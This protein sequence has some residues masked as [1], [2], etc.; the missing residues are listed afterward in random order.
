MKWEDRQNNCG[1]EYELRDKE[2]ETRGREYR[3]E[4]RL[5]ADEHSSIMRW[6]SVHDGCCWHEGRE[7]TRIW[8]AS[9][10]DFFF[11]FWG[12]SFWMSCFYLTAGRRDRTMNV[13]QNTNLE[14]ENSLKLSPKII[15]QLDHSNT[16]FRNNSNLFC[17]C[18]PNVVTNTHVNPLVHAATG[19]DYS[20]SG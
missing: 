5:K 6:T 1:G 4:A 13:S 16:M 11:S 18:I 2:Y 15:E 12:I 10:F 20:T 19:T 3:I 14:K 8:S 7:E 9:S 17:D